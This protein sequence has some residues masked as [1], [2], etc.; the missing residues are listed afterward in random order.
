MRLRDPDGGGAHG[1]ADFEGFTEFVF[2]HEIVEMSA[3]ERVAAI[4]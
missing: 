4:N 2:A 1:K 3:L